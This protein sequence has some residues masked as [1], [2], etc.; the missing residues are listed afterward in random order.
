MPYTGIVLAILAFHLAAFLILFGHW[1]AFAGMLPKAVD[2]CAEQY[3][4]RP[5]RAQREPRR[6][7]SPLV[8]GPVVVRSERS[9]G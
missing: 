1:L 4:R 5:I 3:E 7:S 2:A 8:R 6:G 9:L